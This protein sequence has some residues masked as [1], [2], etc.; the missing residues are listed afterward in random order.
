MV[1]EVA[2][3]EGAK[4]LSRASRRST[5]WFARKRARDL[6][7]WVTPV[8]GGIAFGFTW[9]L[10]AVSSPFDVIAAPA[11]GS[12]EAK[13]LTGGKMGQCSSPVWSPAVK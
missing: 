10:V 2:V 8:L 3:V 12:G 4:A 1:A 11:D 13:N 6:V 9:L 7:V 5:V